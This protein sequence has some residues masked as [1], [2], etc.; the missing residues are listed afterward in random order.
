MKG[1]WSHS[2]AVTLGGAPGSD[3]WNVSAG[4]GNILKVLAF[5]AN[6]T[7]ALAQTLDI[8][9]IDEDGIGI[10]RFASIASA[11]GLKTAT[12]PRLNDDVDTTTSS[13]HGSS[14]HVVL[15]GPD[16]RL[17]VSGSGGALNDVFNVRLWAKV[18]KGPGIITDGFATTATVNEVY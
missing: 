11:T 5:T 18:S 7:T 10:Q 6:W 15:A 2:A 8:L 16:V 1:F 9:L 4:A 3:S 17:V 13:V 14:R 12:I